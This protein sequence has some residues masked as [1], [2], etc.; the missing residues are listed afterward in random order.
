MPRPDPPSGE[1]LA[2]RRVVPSKQ[3]R[4]AGDEDNADEGGKGGQQFAL[5][6]GLAEEDVG[7]QAGEGRGEERE[8]R[9]VGQA[10]A[11]K[12]KRNQLAKVVLVLR[13]IVISRH[14]AERVVETKEAKE[15]GDPA[16]K[17]QSSDGRRA[18][19]WVLDL[20]DH[21]PRGSTKVG[22]KHPHSD[23][24]ARQARKRVSREPRQGWAVMMEGIQLER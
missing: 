13:Q 15:A 6:E 7:E 12:A 22:D 5:G 21:H 4:R 14:V 3:G 1:P 11:K 20:A 2:R 16:G 9:R 10:D 18:E 24:L 8:R 23:D 19:E 17:E